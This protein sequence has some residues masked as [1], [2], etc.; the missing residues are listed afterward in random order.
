VPEI[1]R[2]KP[3]RI[4][5]DKERCSNCL[6]CV[7]VCAER[8]T[9]TSAPGRAHIRLSVDL[10]TGAYVATYCRHCDDAP[11]AAA[12]PVEAIRFDDELGIWRV[13]DE[14]CISCAVC[15]EACTYG[16]IQMDPVTSLAA[17]CDLCLGAVRCVE[18]C[19]T[20]ALTTEEWVD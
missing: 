3:T 14:L 5:W 7:V 18:I 8:H 15:V 11:C 20:Q 19:P 12:C 1:V 16:A 6:S 9:G 4:V 17:K 13:D 10:M 2:V